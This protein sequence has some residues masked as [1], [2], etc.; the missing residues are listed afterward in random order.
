MRTGSLLTILVAF[1]EDSPSVARLEEAVALARS[2]DYEVAE[3]FSGR[4][5]E[6]HPGTFLGS[7]KVEEL[8]QVVAEKKAGVVVFNNPLSPVQ[9][10]NLEKKLA[11]RV[12]D[13]H[14]L[15]LEIFSKRAQSHE[16]KLQVEL[17]QLEHQA[18]RLARG[19]SHLERQRGGSG[20]LAGPGEK[21]VEVDR[22]LLEKRMKHL[23]AR[24]EAA[25]R[26]REVRRRA[27]ARRGVASLSL[28]GYTNAGKSSLFTR[29]T[30]AFS[31]A[32]DRPFTTLDT[33]TRRLYLC[34]GLEVVLTDTVGFVRDLPTELVAA[35]RATLEETVRADLL[36]HVVDLSSASWREEMAE[37]NEVLESI[38]ALAPQI[39]IA[40][41]VD[42]LGLPARS[43]Q[44]GGKTW[45]WMSATQGQGADLLRLAIEEHFISAN[46]LALA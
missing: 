38:G 24:I 42:R 19:W 45:V 3:V 35:F 36:L 34:P 22:R 2:A 15:I 46:A 21:Q 23:S 17:A 1:S 39:L 9:V 26:Q 11:C 33:T 41:K 5:R 12:I 14:E 40:N 44:D 30:H 32:Q 13:R 25:R 4:L 8:G 20:F 7:G 28:V 16:G 31:L 6:I 43:F 27:R 37:T 10:R 18:S 29:L